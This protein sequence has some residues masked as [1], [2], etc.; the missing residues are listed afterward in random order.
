MLIYNIKNIKKIIRSNNGVFVKHKIADISGIKT[1]IRLLTQKLG[2][3]SSFTVESAI[4]NTSS[5]ET[6]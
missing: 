3:G 4:Y 2:R 1:V 6:L 5:Y